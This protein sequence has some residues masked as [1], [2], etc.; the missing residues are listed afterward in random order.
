MQKQLRIAM[1]SV[2]SCP[3]GKLG[4]RDTG[5]MNVY[6]VELARE[7]GRKGHVVDIY[8]R[9]HQPE[10]EQLVS[11]GQNVRLIHLETIRDEEMPKIAI[12][13][14]LQRFTC[15][16]QDFRKCNNL[17]YDLIHSHYWLSG[18][19]GKQ[20]Q[21]WWHIPQV[22]M[23][24][25]LGATK[26]S[27]GIGEDEPE[28]RIESE[29]EVVNNCERIIAAT[30]REREDL[31][32]HYGASP[33]KIAIIPCGVNL[34]LF[35]PV[36]KETARKELSLDHE[37]VILLVGRIEPL[38]GLGQ[39][40]RALTHI[41][42]KEAPRLMI[43]G[44]D[45]HSQGEV[46][47]LQ[48]MARELHIEDQVTFVGSVPQERLP[49][50]YSAADVCVIPS[51]YESFGMVALE[52]LACGTPIVATDVGG[53]RRIIRRSET[54]RIVGD[55]SPRHLASSISELLSQTEEQEQHVEMRRA[56][57]AEFSW[58]NIADMMLQEYDRIVKDYPAGA[59]L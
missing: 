4:G 43:V 52:S 58:A 16:V 8:T 59:S 44:G 35:K 2:H 48:G 30:D 34:G 5:G 57:M 39:M 23:F 22:V 27:I 12:Y 33:Q 18:L 1:I 55:N 13:S 37:K 51:Y 41:T 3:V 9:V 10:H 7:L 47:A 56:V 32:E 6:V 40:F 45:E 28:L 50:F 15:G 29:R 20:L 49:L 38:K 24:H 25:T 42:S 19:V 26:N 53:M 11:L 46:Q 17:D 14:Y 54:G 21:V 36:D 31:I